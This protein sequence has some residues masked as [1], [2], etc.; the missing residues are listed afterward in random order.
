[1]DVEMPTKDGL[2]ALFKEI[3]VEN[4]RFRVFDYFSIP[5]SEEE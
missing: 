5:Y 1:M 3:S 4:I 2:K